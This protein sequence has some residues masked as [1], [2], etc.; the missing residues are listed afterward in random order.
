MLGIYSY[1]S[2]LDL[3]YLYGYMKT[4]DKLGEELKRIREDILNYNQKELA[5]KLKVSHVYLSYLEQGKKAP[6]LELLENL[7]S[8]IG[9]NK[10]P[11]KII[12][13]LAS[14]KG[15]IKNRKAVSHIS[16][17]YI[18]LMEEHGLYDY[19]SLKRFLEKE[20]DNIPVIYG[21]LIL[22]LR[23]NK[24]KEAEQHL[25]DS[26][27]NLENNE[28]K[29]WIQA[30]YNR[31]QGDFELSIQLMIM[32][33]QEF[34]KNNLETKEK[35]LKKKAHL[36]FQTACFYYDYGQYLYVKEKNNEKALDNFFKAIEYH[37]FLREI[38][39]NPNYQMDYASIYFWLAF[40]G[41]ETQKNWAKYI[42]EAK[43][44]LKLNYYEGLNNLPSKNWN[45]VYSKPYIVSTYSFIA[46]SY[47]ELALLEN[48]KD[49]KVEYLK[50]GE[51]LFIQSVPIDIE[52][53]KVEYYRFYFNQACFYSIKAEIMSHLG[54]N[55]EKD[56]DLCYRALSESQR[57]NAV[58]IFK[59]LAGELNS[60][61][62]LVFFKEK[63]KEQ[64]SEILSKIKKEK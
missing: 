24:P 12:K 1:N 25:L 59:L 2:N 56:L 32:A 10:V 57:A 27:K 46:R 40:L 49:K 63:R 55:F 37:H 52:Q 16:N 41:F 26:L 64:L 39:N 36:L 33:Y 22:L 48:D 58:N 19:K 14:S 62:G 31:L 29:K 5:Q 4:K 6:S 54:E 17:N 9:E 50:E 35:K 30:C 60:K 11:D 51:N 8:L 23:D 53:V 44:A 18:Y 42:E 43:E 21:M 15:E 47:A 34:E 45:S 28:D 61:E 3:L 13:L 7:Y 20:P 38:D